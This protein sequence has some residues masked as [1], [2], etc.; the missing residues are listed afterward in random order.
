MEKLFEQLFKNRKRRLELLIFWNLRRPTRGDTLSEI[1]KN[2]IHTILYEPIDVKMTE[3]KLLFF[4]NRPGFSLPYT[5]MKFKERTL[6]GKIY[7][8]RT[9]LFTSCQRFHDNGKWVLSRYK[10]TEELL[11]CRYRRELIR[12]F[13]LFVMSKRN[14]YRTNMRYPLIKATQ[15]LI[16]QKEHRSDI[17]LLNLHD[18]LQGIGNINNLLVLYD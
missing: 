15:I 12:D 13:I 9:Y 18:K 8:N 17:F 3:T 14:P 4:K 2:F 11:P 7:G 6:I 16:D 1:M 10:S 5:H